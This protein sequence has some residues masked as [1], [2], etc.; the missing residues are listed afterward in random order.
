MDLAS[1]QDLAATIFCTKG[2]LD[3][4]EHFY[5]FGKYYLPSET[6]E[7][8][9]IATYKGWAAKKLLT[10]HTGASNDYTAIEGDILSLYRRYL[11]YGAVANVEGFHFKAA[12]FDS[13]QA[14]QMSGN[15][16]KAGISSVPFPKNA[17]TYSPVMDWFTSL[18]LA[19]RVHFSYDDAVLPWCL[20][21]VV[22][23]RDANENLFPNKANKDPLKK[24]DAAVAALYA[25]RLAMV[26]EMLKTP[27][28]NDGVLV[29]FLMED[30]SVQQNGPGGKLITVSAPEV[31]KDRGAH[32]S[33]AQGLMR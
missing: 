6:V 18:V 5:L 23:H 10:V 32:P 11:G 4:V 2:F 26:P 1:R 17:K 8:S 13:W 3:G 24:I 14:Q 22:A 19:G 30:G 16:E 21:N 7:S 29:T 33:D 31:I 27:A 9:P 15:L 28:D 20:N 25:L 12:A